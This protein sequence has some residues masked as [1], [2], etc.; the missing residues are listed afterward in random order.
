VKTNLTLNSLRGNLTEA[1]GTISMEPTVG[2]KLLAT[3]F[4]AIEVQGTCSVIPRR[5]WIY[6]NS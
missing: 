2:S 3:A 4:F 6:A 1:R 5:D